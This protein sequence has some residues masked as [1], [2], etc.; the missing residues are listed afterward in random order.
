MLRRFDFTLVLFPPRNEPRYSAED[1]VFT[2]SV[3]TMVKDILANKP[4]LPSELK[5]YK[6]TTHGERDWYLMKRNHLLTLFL[7]GFAA[8]PN[9]GIPEVKDAFQGAFDQTVDWFKL[10]LLNA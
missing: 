10:H 1:I 5:T 7:K 4:D 9:M 3:K 6:G 8:R 2:E